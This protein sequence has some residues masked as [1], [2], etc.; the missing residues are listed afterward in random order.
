MFKENSIL[1]FTSLDESTQRKVLEHL[2]TKETNQ[3]NIYVASPDAINCKDINNMI[4]VYHLKD[5]ST[6]TNKIEEK[7]NESQK[8]STIKH[9]EKQ[10]VLA[11]PKLQITNVKDIRKQ[12]NEPKR[13]LRDKKLQ[14]EWIEAMHQYNEMKDAAQIL[15]G[16]LAEMRQTTN[17][18]LYP[19]FDLELTD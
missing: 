3:S 1:P 2:G 6:Q 18:S 16:K 12:A 8:T 11:K 13:Q 7:D 9:P 4:A 10:V 5:N 15:L 17:K 14:K 19:E